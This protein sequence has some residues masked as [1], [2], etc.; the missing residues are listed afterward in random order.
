MNWLFFALLSPAVFTVVNFVDKYVV[1]RAVPN[2][3]GIVI[4]VGFLTVI[5]G[6]IF[7]LIAGFP[8]LPLPD[9][10]V[11]MGGGVLALLAAVFYFNAMTQEAASN[12]IVFLQMTP[13]V[14]LTLSFIFLGETLGIEKLLGFALILCAAVGVSLRLGEV[15]VRFSPA[16]LL[17]LGA[18]SFHG[19]SLVLF[20][21]V[22]NKWEFAEVLAYESWGVSIGSVLLYLFYPTARRAFHYNLRHM[23]RSGYVVLGLNES[24][25]MCARTIGFLAISLGSPTLV[26]VLGGTGIFYGI[27]LGWGLTLFAPAVFK[28]DITRANLLRKGVLAVMLF[29]GIILVN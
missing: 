28:E 2:P 27:F 11:I 4:F 5:A 13:V 7:W 20:K 10:A 15:E 19:T 22:T 26:A 24:L 25:F 8:I 6:T 16:L 1:E 21:F 18:A 23:K 12:I 14:V 3:R 17:I 9:A 29:I